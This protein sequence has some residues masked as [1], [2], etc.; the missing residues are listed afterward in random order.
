VWDAFYRVPGLL[1][2]V[3]SSI[4]DEIAIWPLDLMEKRTEMLADASS[5]GLTSG[6]YVIHPCSRSFL[7]PTLSR[8][9]S[10]HVLSTLTCNNAL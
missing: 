1:N 3:T 5:R 8:P 10:S 2:T 6:A 4:D 7:V 9:P